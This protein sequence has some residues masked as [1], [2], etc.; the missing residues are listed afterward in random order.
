MVAGDGVPHQIKAPAAVLVQAQGRFR[1]GYRPALQPADAVVGDMGDLRELQLI[2]ALLG[3]QGAAGGGHAHPAELTAL[4]PVGDVAGHLGHLADVLDLAVQHGPLAVL[5]PLNG[6]HL[7][8]LVLHLPHNSDD[9][10][11]PNVQREN[12]ILVLSFSFDHPLH[13]FPVLNHGPYFRKD[14]NGEYGAP[15]S[16]TPYSHRTRPCRPLRSRA[17]AQSPRAKSLF[18]QRLL[19]QLL[20]IWRR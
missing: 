3:A 5:L 8:A 6:Q 4:Q 1:G 11:G 12:D 15:R 17:T 7:K 10:A 2:A 19:A 18:K 13:L 14:K 20:N 9:A 16:G